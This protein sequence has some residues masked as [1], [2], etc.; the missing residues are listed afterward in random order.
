MFEWTVQ[1]SWMSCSLQ[2]STLHLHETAIR[3]YIISFQWGLNHWPTSYT[4][5]ALTTVPL[6]L[7]SFSKSVIGMDILEYFNFI[8]NISNLVNLPGFM[9]FLVHIKI[10]K[11]IHSIMFWFYSAT[12]CLLVFTATKLPFDTLHIVSSDSKEIRTHNF[13]SQVQPCI[14]YTIQATVS[15]IIWW[16][17]AQTARVWFLYLMF[18]FW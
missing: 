2:S 4:S 16:V 1:E 13:F 8:W 14:H 9:M 6:V 18:I 12:I 10:S 3:Q 15:Y 11:S 7:V 5:D 17:N